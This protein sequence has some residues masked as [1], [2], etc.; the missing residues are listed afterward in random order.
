MSTHGVL[1]SCMSTHITPI[2]STHAIIPRLTTIQRYP[3]MLKR[4]NARLPLY[5][6][7]SLSYTGDLQGWLRPPLTP[8]RRRFMARPRK[9]KHELDKVIGLRIDS[10]TL[11]TWSSQARAAGLSISEWTRL[12][13][14]GGQA[15][16]HLRR[17]RPAAGRPTVAGRHCPGRQQPEPD[18]PGRQPAPVAGANRF[19]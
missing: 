9:T 19:A 6:I 8:R 16:R 1:D 12:R 5:N 14:A 15:L 3:T 2:I 17:A 7:T 13:I 18:R 10:A 11:A 4:K